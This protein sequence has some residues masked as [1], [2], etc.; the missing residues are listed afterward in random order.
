MSDLITA[1]ITLSP[2]DQRSFVNGGSTL[3]LGALGA[4]MGPLGAIALGALGAAMGPQIEQHTCAA[5]NKDM[6]IYY[7]LDGNV[8]DV[9]C[10]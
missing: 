7:T 6:R 5:N 8:T 9:M 10:V 1:A 4:L 2:A 3:I